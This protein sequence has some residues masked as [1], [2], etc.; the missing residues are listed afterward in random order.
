M[1]GGNL[2]RSNK[3]VDSVDVGPG[4]SPGGFARADPFG[5]RPGH[6]GKDNLGVDFGKCGSVDDFRM[7]PRQLRSKDEYQMGHSRGVA[8]E[9]D[10]VDPTQRRGAIGLDPGV[11]LDLGLE[12]SNYRVGVA[13]TDRLVGRDVDPGRCRPNQQDGTPQWRHLQ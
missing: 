2:P 9:E 5:C 1:S 6:S 3:S 10:T 13:Q 12:G 11:G 4:S 7:K 8:W